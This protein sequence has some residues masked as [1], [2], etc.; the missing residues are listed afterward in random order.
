LLLQEKIV[1]GFRQFSAVA[2]LAKKKKLF[3]GNTQWLIGRRQIGLP[4]RNQFSKIRIP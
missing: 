4:L 2:I 3:I 1:F